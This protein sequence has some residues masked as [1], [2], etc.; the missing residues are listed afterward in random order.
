MA[1]DDG[2]AEG[3]GRGAASAAVVEVTLQECGAAVGREEGGEC[4]FIFVF[5]FSFI[6]TFI[7]E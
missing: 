5:A 4:C 1:A 3:E 2:V 6:L 7:V